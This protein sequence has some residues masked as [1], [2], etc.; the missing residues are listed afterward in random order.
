[1]L[2]VAKLK[3]SS[4][5]E[6]AAKKAE[7]K[8]SKEAKKE[9]KR[10]ASQMEAALSAKGV[11]P[12][13]VAI[14][15]SARHHPPPGYNDL[16]HMHTRDRDVRHGSDRHARDSTH[17]GHKHDSSHVH[18]QRRLHSPERRSEPDH[19][20]H[21]R[22]GRAHRDSY[23]DRHHSGEHDR[24]QLGDGGTLTESARESSRRYIDGDANGHQPS[25]GKGH[26]RQGG[27]HY[28]LSWG[29]T[30]PEELQAC[31]RCILLA[32]LFVQYSLAPSLS[33]PV[34]VEYSSSSTI[35]YVSS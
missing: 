20:R 1:M 7:K 23:S 19:D 6:K 10:A 30:A 9:K 14:A 15:A 18:K 27:I 2:Q 33:K 29:E 4:A 32:Y 35:A 5:Q 8:A 28:G 13:S 31:D 24:R 12:Q 3:Q 21:R 11:G 16:V 34:I 25:N 17:N 22:N 26:D